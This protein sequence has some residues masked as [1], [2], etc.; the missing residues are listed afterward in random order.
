MLIVRLRAAA[1]DELKSIGRYTK[2]MGGVNNETNVLL[3]L[4]SLFIF[5]PTIRNWGDSAMKCGWAIGST[6]SVSMLFF[7]A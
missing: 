1:R 4:T 5:W 2:A 3:C 7:I 6:K